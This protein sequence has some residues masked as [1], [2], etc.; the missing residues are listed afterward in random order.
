MKN[1]LYIDKIATRLTF[2]MISHPDAGKTTITEKVLLFG[3]VLKNAGTIKGRGSKQHATSDWMAIEKQR[4]ISITTS[5]MQFP[6]RQA[7]VNLLD[8]PGHEDFSEDTYRTLTAVDCCLMVIDAAKG[9]EERTRNLMAVTRQRD[10]P[11]LTFMNKLDRDIRDPMELIDQVEA[12]LRI[13]CAPITWPIGCGKLFKGLYHLLKN[14]TYLYQ[15]GQGHSIQKIRV[16]KDLNNHELNRALSD[17]LA[18]QLREELKLIQGVSHPFDM[19]AFLAG[20]LTP[21]FFG[22]ALGNFGVDHMLDGLVAWGPPPMPRQ[23][24]VRLVHAGEENFTGFVFKIQANMD[25]RHRDRVAFLRIVS[26]RYEKSMK[27][28]QARTGKAFIADAL[29]FMAGDRS[30]IEEA[31]AGDIIGLHNHGTIQ[32]G[33]TFTQGEELKFTGIPNFAPELFRRIRLRDPLK[34]KSLLKGLVQLSEE[35]AVQVFRPLANNDLI[36]GAVGVLQFEVVVARLKSEYNV[37]ALY[38]PANVFAA[39]WVTCVDAKKLAAFKRKNEL[40]LALDGGK[41]LSYIAPSVVNLKRTRERY[42][43]IQFHKTREH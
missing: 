30:R 6:Y 39:C 18:F 37:D 28:Y 40:N 14:E 17:D 29:T 41:H 16:I 38:E 9:V 3:N 32:I 26:G 31:Y 11:I 23:T 15:S 21:V 10:T 1:D 43:D 24:D 27:L 34:Q 42:P 22:T 2:A 25:P 4:G 12:E 19:Q 36:V 8:T 13:A 20:K 35:G 33:D 7:L 5:V